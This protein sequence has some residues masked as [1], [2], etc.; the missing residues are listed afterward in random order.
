MRGNNKLVNAATNYVEAC[1]RFHEA[2]IMINGSF[3]FGFDCDGP[4]VFERTLEIAVENK[5]LTASFHIL[6]PL[7]GTRLFERL[8]T[9]GRILHRNWS[10]YDTYHAVFRPRRMTPEQLEAGYNQARG[11]FAAWNSILHRSLGLPGALK[12]IAYNIAWMKVDPLWVAIIRAG[13]MPFATRMFER[14]LRL[15]TKSPSTEHTTAPWHVRA[16]SREHST[17]CLV[18]NNHPVSRPGGKGGV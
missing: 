1:R 4:G 13:L 7:P 18:L 3:V 12:R 16:L 14:V 5:I 15:K 2:G 17:Q 10:L 9:E 11:Q 6:T 8:E